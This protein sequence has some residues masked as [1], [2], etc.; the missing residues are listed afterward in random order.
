MLGH[1][2]AHVRGR[3]HHYALVVLR[4]SSRGGGDRLR[5]AAGRRAG[6]AAGR[7]R[8]PGQHHPHPRGRATGRGSCSARA[9]SAPA[10]RAVHAAAGRATSTASASTPCGRTRAGSRPA[11]SPGPT[12]CSC[13]RPGLR[14]RGVARDGRVHPQPARHVGAPGRGGRGLRGVHAALSRGVERSRHPLAALDRPQPDDLRRPRRAS[15][16]GTSRGRGSRTPA[17]QPWWHARIT[18]AFMAYWLYQHLGNLAPPELEEEPMYRRRSRATRTSA[19]SWRR[20]PSAR[21][22]SRRRRGGRAAAT[23][24]ARGWSSSTR[25]AARVL[26]DGRRD[27][28]DEEEWEWIVERSHEAPRPPGHREHPAGV[29]VPGRPLPRGVERGGVRRRLGAPGGVG[30]RAHP[31]RAR[32][33]A[34]AGVPGARSRRWSTCSGTS[35]AARAGERRRH[36]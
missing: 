13:R 9:G 4:T 32:P 36:P 21:T 5:G 28:V 30:R 7:R 24:A 11:S 35:R 18:G 20:S 14:R 27:M 29:H 19:R 3:G 34:L 22:A 16:T 6:V 31:P 10:A 2:A 26:A 1:V 25:A 23:S 17:S 8:A 15:T 12:R 33:G